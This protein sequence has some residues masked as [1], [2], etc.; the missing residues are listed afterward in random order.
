MTFDNNIDTTVDN[1]F[2]SVILTVEKNKTKIQDTEK[3]KKVDDN[4]MI[5][6]NMKANPCYFTTYSETTKYL[7]NTT[8]TSVGFGKSNCTV[9]SLFDAFNNVVYHAGRYYSEKN[10]KTT[11]NLLRA[12]YVWYHVK[13]KKP[14]ETIKFMFDS[15]KNEK[16]LNK[17][18]SA[19]RPSYYLMNQPKQ[20][21]A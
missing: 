9:C 17:F 13:P 10:K 5:I 11:Y 6:K 8:L 19:F 4:L 21:A 16:T 18:K 12:I 15:I 2:D 3:H 7:Y 14:L 1:F 20:M